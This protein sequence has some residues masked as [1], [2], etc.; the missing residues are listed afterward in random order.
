MPRKRAII[1]EDITVAG[2]VV[3]LRLRRRQ[4]FA[5]TRSNAGTLVRENNFANR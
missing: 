1:L 4:D 3:L 2:R 5:Q